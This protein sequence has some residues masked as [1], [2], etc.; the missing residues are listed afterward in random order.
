MGETGQQLKEIVSLKKICQ[1]E[2]SVYRQYLRE[3]Y[4]PRL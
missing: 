2:R 1:K 4:R 3:L